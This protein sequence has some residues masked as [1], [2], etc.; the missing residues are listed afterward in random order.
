MSTPSN[1]LASFQSYEIKHILLAFRN[2]EQAIAHTVPYFNIGRCGSVVGN[3]QVPGYVIVNE[4]ADTSWSIGMV[5]WSFDFI[6]PL[7]PNTTVALGELTILDSRG[8]QFPS[9]FR[10]ISKKMKIPE[11]EMVFK[12]MSMVL[13]KYA[14]GTS[15]EPLL[16]KPVYFHL[17]DTASGFRNG[18]VNQFVMN[19]T[20]AYNSVA[21]MPQYSLLSQ[22]TITNSENNPSN[23]IPL[24]KMSYE[25]TA[26]MTSGVVQNGNT[27]I[28][29]SV[30]VTPMAT[31]NVP[32]PTSLFA[33]SEPT[34]DFN[35]IGMSPDAYS[36]A[37]TTEFNKAPTWSVTDKSGSGLFK[38]LPQPAT[39]EPTP[40]VSLATR[41]TI[42]RVARESTH[43]IHRNERLNTNKPMK[44]LKD[45]FNGFELDLNE[46]RFVNKNQVQEFTSIIKPSSLKKTK[47]PKSKSKNEELPL[48]FKIDLESVYNDYPIDNRNLLTE[49]IENMQTN[50]GI[51]SITIP[52]GYNIITAVELLMKLSTKTGIDATN[53]LSYKVALSTVRDYENIST[54]TVS[55]RQ[56]EIPKN[57][58]DVID[59]ASTKY[60][61]G[62]VT[63]YEFNF[64]DTENLDI[65][66]IA[67]ASSP[68]NDIK[69]MTELDDDSKNGQTFASSQQEPPVV[70]RADFGGFSGL[71]NT[72]SP[73]NYGLQ[74]F[75]S[76]LALDIATRKSG[77]MQNTL[78][79]VEIIG[80]PDL[81]SD[82]ARD[83]KK[84]AEHLEDSPSLFRFPEH[85]PMY[86]KI[87]I[88]IGKSNAGA[89]AP[90]DEEIWYHT[91]NYHLS[92][93]SNSIRSGSFTQTLRLLSTDDSI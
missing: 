78:S 79:V 10:R 92:G 47:R 60:A 37:A 34:G 45:V 80:N 31:S 38:N 15:A 35:V 46:M 48:K 12:L 88:K 68:P 40:D 53:G 75:V 25:S 81:Y 50:A 27:N 76:G 70:E 89:L 28:A 1:P 26:N 62:I 64:L 77:I 71:R 20:L 36:N 4:I 91:Y 65:S 21:Q 14:D 44:T 49:Q 67:I 6:S 33:P 41:K 24:A 16:L 43:N 11:T 93:V 5:D 63:P 18:M 83:P 61:K 69:I 9:F 90:E 22:F 86:C 58:Q 13:G 2:T 73:V 85:Y 56:Y 29:Q 57:K 55:I 51:A 84:V 42:N 52:P 66:Y 59:T 7:S 23:S 54:I 82:L 39:P 17:L 72:T 87:R 19:F 32:V 8:N 3:V 30:T 74:D